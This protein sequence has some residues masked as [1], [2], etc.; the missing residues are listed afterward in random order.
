MW[1]YRGW[2]WKLVKSKRLFPRAA[3]Y[4]GGFINNL[5]ATD[6]IKI[7]P[8]RPNNLSQNLANDLWPMNLK[9]ISNLWPLLR[10][11]NN[12]HLLTLVTIENDNKNTVSKTPRYLQ[13]SK[14]YFRSCPSVNS[15]Q[16]KGLF[17]LPK[18]LIRMISCSQLVNFDFIIQGLCGHW[19]WEDNSGIG[20]NLKK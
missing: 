7:Y 14:I 17:K 3:D 8:V 13:V 16:M 9:F 15:D 5:S 19:R 4:S 18:S 10:T 6:I 20:F 2:I 1:Y 11:S 12:R